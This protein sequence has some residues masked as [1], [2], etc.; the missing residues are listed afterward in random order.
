[1]GQLGQVAFNLNSN[2][3]V[4]LNRMLTFVCSYLYLYCFVILILSASPMFGRGCR[5]NT[6]HPQGLT[7]R[8]SGR[9]SRP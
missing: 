1:M 2:M 8:Y 7:L 3:Q 6:L 5:A 9:Q 4:I